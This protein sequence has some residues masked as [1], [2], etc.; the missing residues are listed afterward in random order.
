MPPKIPKT[1]SK[2]TPDKISEVGE[3]VLVG[4]TISQQS[5]FFG[6]M[7]HPD[8]M[9]GYYEID[10]TFPDRLLKIVEKEQD[11]RQ[12]IELIV[13]GKQFNERRL[14]QIFGLS[15]GIV[16]IIAGVYTAVNG[17]QIA[18]S[19]IGGGGITG[20]VA[21]FVVGRRTVKPESKQL[22]TK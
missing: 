4:K 19:I 1:L 22:T 2:V 5:I 7:P 12:K 11:H 3:K 17:A 18:G 20:L 8:E 21:V 10:Q 15:I 16:A 13:V 14:G 6:P 9:R